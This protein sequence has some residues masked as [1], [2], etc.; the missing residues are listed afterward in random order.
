MRT[1]P[2]AGLVLS[3]LVLRTLGRAPERVGEDPDRPT[4]RAHIFHLAARHPV[5]DRPAAHSNNLASFHD[6]E[7]LS[8]DV[9]VRVLPVSLLSEQRLQ[10][11]RVLRGLVTFLA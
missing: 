2:G 3:L 10:L 9:H 5:V 8:F 7:R 1:Q 11:C 4:G 6:R